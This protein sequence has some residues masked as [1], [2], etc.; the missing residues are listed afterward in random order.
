[1]VYGIGG[2]MILLIVGAFLLQNKEEEIPYTQWSE[3]KDYKV[4]ERQDGRT[5][6][7]NQKAGFSFVVPDGWRV[8]NENVEIGINEN[9]FVW[10]LYHPATIGEFLESQLGCF[11][12]LQNIVDGM[13][14]ELAQ[15]RIKTI[16]QGEDL[17]PEIR[18]VEVEGQKAEWFELIPPSE[19]MYQ[20][21]GGN[22]RVMIPYHRSLIEVGMRFSSNYE[23]ECKQAFNTF[24]EDL[25]IF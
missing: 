17:D 2:V 4:Q 5:E 9:A 10:K 11:V 13:E 6:I 16:E 20:K 8:E 1:M 3:E 14:I 12:D 22:I 18:L 19:D 15:E 23:Q 7:I 25:R 21:R 24:I